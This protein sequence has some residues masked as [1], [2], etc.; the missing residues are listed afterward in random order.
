M[1][2]GKYYIRNI[3]PD[4]LFIYKVIKSPDKLGRYTV[5]VLRN[6]LFKNSI[7][8]RDKPIPYNLKVYEIEF[9]YEDVEYDSFKDMFVDLL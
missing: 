7:L 2:V 8:N 1:I 4:K 6:D 5:K 9:G 3:Y